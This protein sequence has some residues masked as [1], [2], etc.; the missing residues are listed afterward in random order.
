MTYQVRAASISDGVKIAPLLRE[1]DKLE[2]L[3]ATGESVAEALVKSVIDSDE[4]YIAERPDGTPLAIY[5]MGTDG[6]QGI[7]WMVGTDLMLGYRKA[8]IKD[9]R[10]WIEDRLPR[11]T[12]LINIVDARNTEHV[13]W[14]RH[15][16]FSMT[17]PTKGLGHDPEVPFITFYRTRT[18]CA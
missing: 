6:H 3:A 4:A 16:G 17:E 2:A 11:Y 14:L 18:Q 12:M 8:L 7:P 13:N 15:M 5:G 10:K 1:A 9:A